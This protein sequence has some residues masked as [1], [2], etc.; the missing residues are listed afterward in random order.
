VKPLNTIQ[1]LA[2]V[3]GK[4]GGS[5][6]YRQKLPY[7]R[8]SRVTAENY[9]M[10]GGNYGKYALFLVEEFRQSNTAENSPLPSKVATFSVFPLI[11]GG[12]CH[13]ESLHFL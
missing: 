3:T 1:F 11:F 5:K 2:V 4:T 12:F 8:R 13:R 10:F 6:Y 9:L 7:V